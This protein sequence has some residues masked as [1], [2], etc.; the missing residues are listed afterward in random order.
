[1]KKTFL[2]FAGLAFLAFKN[3]AQTVTDVDNNVYNTVTIGTQVWMKE[4]LK[5]THYSN[6]NLIPNVTDSTAWANLSSGARCYYDN[7]STNY[8]STYGALYNYYT[9]IDNSK[10]CPVNWHIPSDAELMILLAFLGGDSIAGGKM[11]ETGTLH[12]QSPNTGATNSS[13]FTAIP[14]GWR[15]SPNS[16]PEDFVSIGQD[17]M[18]WFSPLQY[19]NGVYLNIWYGSKNVIEMI[20]GSGDGMKS[21]FSVRCLRDLAAQINEIKNKTEIEFYPNPAIDRININC[22][23]TG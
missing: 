20:T 10:L 13:G 18:W 3:Q 15:R 4:N 8:S 17:G 7:D 12:W 16:G 19:L 5:V 21:G 23:N 6:G 22:A 14:G 1:M 9:I 11:K 2:L